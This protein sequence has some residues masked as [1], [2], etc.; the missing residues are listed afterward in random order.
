[1][2]RYLPLDE[3]LKQIRL[4]RSTEPLNMESKILDIETLAGSTQMKYTPTPWAQGSLPI[5]METF[6]LLQMPPFTAISYVWGSPEREHT[7]SCSG[8]SLR[9]TKN[10]KD[11][12]QILTFRPGWFWADAICIDQENIPERNSQVQLMKEIYSSASEVVA[13]VGQPARYEGVLTTLA[14][15]E[16]IH[17]L[18]EVN[19]GRLVDETEIRKNR[20]QFNRAF[21]DLLSSPWFSRAWIMQEA[22]LN[23]NFNIWYGNASFS[24]LHLQDFVLLVQ[25]ESATWNLNSWQSDDGKSGVIADDT[26]RASGSSPTTRD[27]GRLRRNFLQVDSMMRMSAYLKK[28]SVPPV[29]ALMLGRNAD[30]SDPRDKVYSIM[31]LVD[32]DFSKLMAPDYSAANT[33]EAVY[34]KAAKYLLSTEHGM[35]LLGQAGYSREGL[36]SWAPDWSSFQFSPFPR[37]YAASGKSPGKVEFQTQD[38]ISVHGAIIDQV[39]DT[40]PK[41]NFSFG[42]DIKQFDFLSDDNPLGC[43]SFFATGLLDMMFTEKVT[44]FYE[45]EAYPT[46]ENLKDVIWRSLT[47]DHSSK[48]DGRAERSQG[49]LGYDAFG[50]LYRAP[51]QGGRQPIP[52][53]DESTASKLADAYHL[54]AL[55]IQHGRRGS[56]TRGRYMATLPGTAMENDEI[57]IVYGAQMPLV[58]R[59]VGNDADGR[60]YRLIGQAYVHGIMDGEMIDFDEETKTFGVRGKHS[61]MLR[62]V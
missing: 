40:L 18:N 23:K 37:A 25:R 44:S 31:G 61:E 38:V 48:L 32:D 5:S 26:A 59:P 27:E 33:V 43:D 16:A 20:N 53:I 35:S 17:F 36:P 56:V 50:S 21:T 3:N 8:Q 22:V 13:H 10:L 41:L 1:M 9:V 19:G 24:L 55:F 46:G 60:R 15:D 39:Q 62:I 2:Y 30:A 12:L 45:K 49:R 28:G 58:L 57:A 52:N 7:I 42:D 47:A 54:E 11:A 14:L 29:R 4:F 51:Q 6:S 34:K